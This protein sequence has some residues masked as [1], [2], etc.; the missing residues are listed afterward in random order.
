MPGIFQ[1]LGIDTRTQEEILKANAQKRVD[2]ARNFSLKRPTFAGEEALQR[3]GR[4]AGAALRNKFGGSDLTPEQERTTTALS[5]AQRRLDE[6]EETDP[7]K[8]AT[9]SQKLIAEELVR[10]GDPRGA[11][12]MQAVIAQENQTRKQE[13][14]LKKLGLQSEGLETSNEQ[15]AFNLE[16]G[17]IKAAREAI[18]TVYPKN[19]QDPNSGVSLYID[20]EGNAKAGPDGEIILPKG[21]YT[22]ARPTRAPIGGARGRPQDFGISSNEAKQVRQTHAGLQTQ[23]RLA[24]TMRDTFVAAIESGRGTV[25][26]MGAGGKTTKFVAD[27]VNGANA[28]GRQVLLWTGPDGRQVALDG[29]PASANRYVKQNGDL[30]DGFDVPESVRGNLAATERYKAAV[31]QMAYAKARIAEPGARQLSDTDFSNALQQI[32]ANATDPEAL[33]QILFGDIVRGVEAYDDVIDTLRPEAY[34]SIIAQPGQKGFR[35]DFERFRDGFGAA[36]G[37]ASDPEEGLTS[38]PTD[39]EQGSQFNKPEE[40][41][42]GETVAQRKARLLSGS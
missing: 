22:L 36:F 24:N 11:Q 10:A 30:F 23:M 41:G 20:A 13:L 33:R 5:E 7:T 38:P 3:S 35:E 4:Q 8:R 40:N 14:E 34:E 2:D 42:T 17:K 26:I 25:D 1:Q 21:T 19:S 31:V 16:N 18:K 27:F 32:G 28:V 29:S 39:P 9:M 6:S 37:S 12:L 15:S